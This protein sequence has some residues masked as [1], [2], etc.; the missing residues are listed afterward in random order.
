MYTWLCWWSRFLCHCSSLLSWCVRFRCIRSWSEASE[1]WSSIPHGWV[2]DSIQYNKYRIRERS[3]KCIST[4]ISREKAQIYP[5]LDSDDLVHGQLDKKCIFTYLLTLYHGLKNREVIGN[6]LL[7]RWLLLLIHC[8][9]VRICV[10]CC[11]NNLLVHCC[12]LFFS[13]YSE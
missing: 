11:A 5:L 10:A 1:S 13:V 3:F 7:F 8:S 12:S 6:K 2:S 4:I 9:Y